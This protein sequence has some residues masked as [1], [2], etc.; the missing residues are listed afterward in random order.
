MRLVD[1]VFFID[2][3]LSLNIQWIGKYIVVQFFFFIVFDYVYHWDVELKMIGSIDKEH[4]SPLL[5]SIKNANL[6]SFNLL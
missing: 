5:N 2:E 3:F 4:K 6:F 1:R